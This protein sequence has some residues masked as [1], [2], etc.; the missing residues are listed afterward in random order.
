MPCDVVINNVGFKFCGRGWQDSM[1]EMGDG[2]GGDLGVGAG[3]LGVAGGGGDL[4]V[5][6]SDLGVGGG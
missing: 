3:D 4:G 6:G 2:S 1:E 5:G